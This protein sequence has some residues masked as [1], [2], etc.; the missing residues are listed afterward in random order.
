M[1]SPKSMAYGGL[2]KTTKGRR[3]GRKM[4]KGCGCSRLSG[5]SVET[6]DR[7]RGHGAGSLENSDES[8]RH[9]FSVPSDR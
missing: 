8:V 7:G 5:R 4:M 3:K 2:E 9:R 6:V 1:S